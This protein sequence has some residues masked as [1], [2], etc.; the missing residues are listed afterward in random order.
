MEKYL[1]SRWG[2]DKDG[3][4]QAME[5]TLKGEM[6]VLRQLVEPADENFNF[7]KRLFDLN[8]SPLF[9]DRQVR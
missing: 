1:E 5:R 4:L 8:L 6:I 7:H 3:N 2:K 9:P